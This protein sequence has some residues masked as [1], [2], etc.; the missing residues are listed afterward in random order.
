MRSALERCQGLLNPPP[1]VVLLLKKKQIYTNKPQ[2][3]TQIFMHQLYGLWSKTTQLSF[4]IGTLR[5][6]NKK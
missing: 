5:N 3:I 2:K 6:D 4:P 1:I